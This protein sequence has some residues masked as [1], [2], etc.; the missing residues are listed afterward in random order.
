MAGSARSGKKVLGTF[1]PRGLP[2]KRVTVRRGKAPVLSGCET[3]PATG[4]LRSARAALADRRPARDASGPRRVAER[5]VV[6]MTPRRR[7]PGEGALVEGERRKRRGTGDWPRA[8]KA[9]KNK[10]RTC[11]SGA[12]QR[13]WGSLR[14]RSQAALFLAALCFL[15]RSPGI[16][17]R[18]RAVPHP[19]VRPTRPRARP[20]CTPRPIQYGSVWTGVP[21]PP[22][23]NTGRG[24]TSIAPP[25]QSTMR[26]I[27]ALSSHGHRTACKERPGRL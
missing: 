15:S 5:P 19:S 6:P 7:G 13:A 14:R 16:R 9:A 11:R 10:P 12:S 22:A 25:P 3:R 4:S 20:R 24:S 18:A 8:R 21:Q 2:E 1:L 27:G 17:P 26:T 23:P